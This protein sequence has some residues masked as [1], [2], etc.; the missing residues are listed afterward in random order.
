MFQVLSS[1]LFL[2]LKPAPMKSFGSI[3]AYFIFGDRDLF[4]SLIYSR[5]LK[6]SLNQL[7]RLWNV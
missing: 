7:I 4:I 3:T 2:L 1:S 6:L 5:D